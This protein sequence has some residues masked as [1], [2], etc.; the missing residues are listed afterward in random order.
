[1][2][3]RL[4][5]ATVTTVTDPPSAAGTRPAL[6]QFVRATTT[7]AK[8]RLLLVGLVLLSLIWGVIAA[9]VV[10]QRT[11]G[12]N[13]VVSSSET[14]SLDG[15]QI[16]RAL[17]DADATAASAFLAGGLEPIDGPRRYQAD[18]AQAAAHL[19]SA[20]AAAGHSPAAADLAKLSA[21]LPVYTGEIQTA[22][23]DNRLGL[24]LGAAY[25]REASGLM[26][27][28]LLPA[29]RN[30]SAEA[31]AQ[32]AAA[33]G[34]A[35]GLP[36]LLVLLVAAVI[37]GFVLYRAQRWLLRHTHRVF[38]P[39]L[40]VASVAGLLSLLWLATALTVARADLLQARDHGSTPVTALARADIAALQARADESLTLIDAEGDDS[41]QADF[42]AVQHRLG[43][44]PGT[45]L[46]EAVA[47]AH[48]SPGAGSAQAAATAATAWYA[49]HRMV[50]FLDDNGRHTQA[51]RLVTAPGPGHSSTKFARL[52]G[53]LTSAIAADQAV[54]RA[55][56]VAGRNASTALEAG[57]IVLSLIMAAGCAFGLTR[58]LAEYR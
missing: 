33:S 49:A 20:T 12:A 45:L 53:S 24:P 14:L 39:G 22:R 1:L 51:I 34:R 48:G 35:T 56:A 21:G 2:A 41:F 37:V 6:R 3:A 9:W 47:A 54:F 31:D 32:L 29:A 46:T 44:G 52:D 15:Q 55:K 18:I 16:Y 19:E 4:A 13:D 27:G 36:L 25:L 43:P 40:A 28:T 26:R 10:S 5:G 50:R 8:L 42:L 38:N 7:P 58:R 30:I 17:S 11:S 57:V 23:A